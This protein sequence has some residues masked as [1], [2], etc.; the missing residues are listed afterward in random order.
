MAVGIVFLLALMVLVVANVVVRAFGG[1]IAPTYELSELMIVV[2][3]AFALVYT[4]KEK[5][6]V[7]VDILVPRLPRR[8]QAI[9]QSFTL[10]LSVGICALIGWA[11][12]DIMRY[13]WLK[14]TTTVLELPYL[15]FRGIWV[16]S[17]LLVFLVLLFDLFKAL[18]Q[19]DKK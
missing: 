16:F 11:G 7:V 14:E 12:F 5:G 9:L 3:V 15:P 10:F 8:I 18:R 13:T 6:H 19:E 4:T 17:L 1:G 2:A